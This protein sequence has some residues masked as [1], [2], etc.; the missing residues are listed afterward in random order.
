MLNHEVAGALSDAAGTSDGDGEDGVAEDSELVT[1]DVLGTC[2]APSDVGGGDDGNG[3]EASSR[4]DRIS[5]RRPAEGSR[6][7]KRARRHHGDD[8]DDDEDDDEDDDDEEEEEEEDD[9]ESDLVILDSE[10]SDVEIV[11]EAPAPAPARANA[12]ATTAATARAP[13]AAVDPVHRCPPYYDP[14]H[15]DEELEVVPC[16]ICGR[17]NDDDEQFMLCDGRG[18]QF[19]QH[20]FARLK[21]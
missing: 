8:D 7:R 9:S 5:E 10:S 15:S 6:E 16:M 1:E 20:V 14:D 13:A 17:T 11:D 18:R 19:P 21:A 3:D 12:H 2:S 4:R